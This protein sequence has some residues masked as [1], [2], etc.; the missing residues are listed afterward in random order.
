MEIRLFKPQRCA[1][2]QRVHF[3]RIRYRWTHGSPIA[4]Q[5]ARS[6]GQP[7]PLQRRLGR[8]FRGELVLG[9]G[10]LR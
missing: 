10:R 4:G 5:P 3:T 7:L 8:L 2:D 1:Q 6:G 9:R